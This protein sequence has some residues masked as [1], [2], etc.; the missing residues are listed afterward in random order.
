MASSFTM[1]ETTT[2]PSQWCISYEQLLDVQELALK[3]FGKEEYKT[4]TMRDICRHIILPRCQETGT[5]YALS[6]NPG[7]LPIDS[8][9][10]HSWDGQ[11]ASFVQSIQNVFQTSIHKPNLWICAFALNQAAVNLEETL[12]DSPFVQALK[13]ASSFCVVRNSNTDLY[14][15]IWCVCELMYASNSENGLYPNQTYVTGPNVFAGLQTSCLDAKATRQEDKD[16]ILR[17]LFEDYDKEEIDT[18]VQIFRRHGTPKQFD[19]GGDKPE[20]HQINLQSILHPLSTL[21]ES[22]IAEHLS[23][24]QPGTRAWAVNGFDDWLEGTHNLQP[25]NRVFVL[26]GQAGIGKTGIACK[27]IQERKQ[28][29]LAY[30]FCRHDDSRRSDPKVMLLSLV[31]QMSKQIPEYDLLVEKIIQGKDLTR[32]ALLKDY[33]VLGIFE[34]LISSPLQRVSVPDKSSRHYVVVVDA[35]DECSEDLGKNEMLLCIQRHFLKLPIWIKFF[36]TTRP[37]VPIVEKLKKFSPTMIMPDEEH[38]RHDL[39]VYFRNL[40]LE[41]GSES[42]RPGGTDH[43]RALVA[44]TNKAEGLFIF[45]SYLSDMVRQHMSRIENLEELD[46]VPT[47]LE[48]FYEMQLERILEDT[49]GI[50]WQ[51]IEYITAAREPLHVE[52]IQQLLKLSRRERIVAF[53][54]LSSFFPIDH[55]R[56]VRAAH[57]SLTD[58]LVDKGREDAEFFVDVQAVQRK[59]G[60]DCL[61]IL[62][63]VGITTAAIS[64]V[65]SSKADLHPETV[66]YAL[67]HCVFHLCAGSMQQLAQPLLLNISYLMAKAEARESTDLVADFAI[68]QG[69]DKLLHL[70]GRTIQL[71]LHALRRDPHQLPGQLV[72]RLLSSSEAASEDAAGLASFLEKVKEYHYGFDWFCPIRP[73]WDQA[74]QPCICLLEGHRGEVLCLTTSVDG[75]R[76]ATGSEDGTVRIWNPE[77]GECQMILVGHRK[78]INAL[79]WTGKDSNRI[80]SGSDDRSIRVWDAVTGDCEIRVRENGAVTCLD[81]TSDGKVIAFAV[82]AGIRAWDLTTRKEIRDME[83]LVTSISLLNGGPMLAISLDDGKIFVLNAND[84]SVIRYLPHNMSAVSALAWSIDGRLASCRADGSLQIWEQP[85]CRMDDLLPRWKQEAAK[86]SI[87]QIYETAKPPIEQIYDIP[88]TSLAWSPDGQKIAI[89]GAAVGDAK[90]EILLW[91]ASSN[92]S[93]RLT[94]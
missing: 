78:A 80:L 27:I 25:K 79:A 65:A 32:E 20:N 30:H 36:V 85:L 28:H 88:L 74:S 12:E 52:A 10:T 37:E 81:V 3:V 54:L 58:W 17:V 47:G 77:T 91:D 21:D 61:G 93:D 76:V 49:C 16:K 39:M 34:E 15:R 69:D 4:V 87:E 42:L 5:S 6:L 19:Q 41:F 59:I 82:G 45:A 23:R 35:L 22:L 43:E 70:I 18:I 56:K 11:F 53:W 75:S 2:S 71:S 94:L 68:A 73:T 51:I 67:R 92:K 44:L 60:E 83:W 40:L 1:T 46:Q 55:N 64:P 50:E 57:K 33:S 26:T 84:G 90:G 62:A 48:E 86:P 72:G 13:S 66:L 63:Q 31:Y 89:G 7:G 24:F 8:F 9:V 29:I 38:N 14:S